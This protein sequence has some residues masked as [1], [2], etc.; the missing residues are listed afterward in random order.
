MKT[1]LQS[2]AARVG[3]S[4]TY[5]YTYAEW[6]E[7]Q[8][9]ACLDNLRLAM[10]RIADG[11]AAIRHLASRQQGMYK[12]RHG[13]HLIVFQILAED[14]GLVVRVLHERM[15]IDAHLEKLSIWTRRTV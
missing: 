1:L 12:L 9:D 7:A 14:R 5:A 3:L 15:D 2:K 11:T 4:E 6:R 8:A 10:G 13:R